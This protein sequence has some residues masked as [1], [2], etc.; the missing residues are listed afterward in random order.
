MPLEMLRTVSRVE[1][2]VIVPRF[3]N[4]ESVKLWLPNIVLKKDPLLIGVIWEFV[5]LKAS[6]M[7]S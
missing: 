1:T 6:S 7:V 3:D 2:V 4:C 5:V